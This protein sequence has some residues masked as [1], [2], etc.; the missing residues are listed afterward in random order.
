MNFQSLDLLLD[1]LLVREQRGHCH[2]RSQ[3]FRN[4]V[5][6]CHSR[7][8]PRSEDRH[9]RAIDQRHGEIRRR[10]ERKE[11][12]EHKARGLSPPA[13]AD[14]HSSKAMT[15]AVTTARRSEIARRG[16]PD[17]PTQEPALPGHPIAEFPFKRPASLRDE[18][19]ARVRYAAPAP[20]AHSHA[21]P[22][23]PAWRDPQHGSSR[24]F[25]RNP[26]HGTR[27]SMAWRYVS[28]V[29]KSISAYRGSR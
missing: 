2:D 10:H 20:A 8:W 26:S 5:P 1:A 14:R 13:S 25:L 23:V 21:A 29:T 16:S 19:I 27:S 4:A 11:T 6:Q 9:D 12:E 7:Q 24:R 18:V 15:M 28:R 3:L 17:I 22:S